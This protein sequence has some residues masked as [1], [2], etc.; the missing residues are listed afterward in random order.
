[1]EKASFTMG[2]Y[3]RLFEEGQKRR[4]AFRTEL[5]NAFAKYRGTNDPS[6]LECFHV[7]NEF[8][9]NVILWLGDQLGDR[10]LVLESGEA[11]LTRMIERELE[12]LGSE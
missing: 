2:D 9:I 10:R 7:M 3:V 12:R 11:T 8:Y 5:I 1:M 4:K 6:D